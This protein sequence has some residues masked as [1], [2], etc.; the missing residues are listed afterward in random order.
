MAGTMM[1]R[2]MGAA[3]LDV[4]TYEEVERDEGATTQAA[5]VVALVAVAGALGASPLGLIGAVKAGAGITYLIGDKLFGGHAT[6]GEVLRTLGFAQAPGVLLILGIIPILGTPV[7]LLVGLWM[8]V[9]AFIGLRQALD[10]GNGKTFA[11]VLVGWLV[12]AVLSVLF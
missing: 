3:F 10:L 11:T 6:W 9:T 1:D 8:L 4:D 5:S 12:Y 2:M 7:T